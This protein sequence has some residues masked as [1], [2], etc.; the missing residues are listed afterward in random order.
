M[1]VHDRYILQH[2]LVKVLSFDIKVIRSYDKLAND[3]SL[4]GKISVFGAYT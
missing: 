1:Y 2:F 4:V 3:N